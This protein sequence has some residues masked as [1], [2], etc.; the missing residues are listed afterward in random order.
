V[1]PAGHTQDWN[2]EA[3]PFDDQTAPWGHDAH[4]HHHPPGMVGLLDHETQIRPRAQK[5][6]S[7][8]GQ[9]GAAVNPHRNE[10]ARNTG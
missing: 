8:R 3:T 5:N 9:R 6:G 4:E 2:T 10:T 7:H 1:A